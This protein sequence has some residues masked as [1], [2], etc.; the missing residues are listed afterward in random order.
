MGERAGKHTLEIWQMALSKERE[1]DH[2]PRRLE[3]SRHVHEAT[4]RSARRPLIGS[5]IAQQIRHVA[6][7]ALHRRWI[8]PGLR[9]G[10]SDPCAMAENALAAE[11]C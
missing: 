5:G 8:G 3:R 2:D 7:G 11:A 4:T 10:A 6:R 1:T 9:H